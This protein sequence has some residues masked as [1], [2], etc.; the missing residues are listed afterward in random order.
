M[1]QTFHVRREFVKNNAF[2]LFAQRLERRVDYL[3][4]VLFVLKAR[5]AINQSPIRFAIANNK[6]YKSVI[7]SYVFQ[8][9]DH[10]IDESNKL[11]S[12][13]QQTLKNKRKPSF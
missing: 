1:T 4:R 9:T 12:L 6:S 10:I 3:V 8:L 5:H 2:D 11:C 13:T 7:K